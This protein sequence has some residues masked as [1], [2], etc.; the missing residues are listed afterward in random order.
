MPYLLRPME[1]GDVPV[2]TAIDRLSFPTPWPSAAFHHE[3]RRDRAY[4]YVLLRPRQKEVSS[5]NRNWGGWLR[6]H[7]DPAKGSRIVGYVGFRLRDGEGHITTIAV[8]PAWRGRGFG[9]LLLTAALDEML[10]HGVDAVTLET[11]PTNK[12][13]HQLYH[14]YGFKV[15]RRRR[16]YYRDGEDAWVMTSQVDSEGYRQRLADLREALEERLL[17]E[18]IEVGHVRGRAQRS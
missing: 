15:E 3:L 18:R 16:G 11:R 8:H 4:Y 9:A 6:R 12:V 5:S 10:Q 2:V 14:Q 7:L 17:D 13:A 1:A